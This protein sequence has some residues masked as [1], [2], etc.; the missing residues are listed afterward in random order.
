MKRLGFG[1]RITAPLPIQQ[2][3]PAPGQGIVAIETR[4]DDDELRRVLATMS[5]AAAATSFEAERTLVTALGGGCQLPLGGIAVHD[6]SDLEMH[7]IVLSPDGTRVI[8][9]SG[10]ASVA[11]PAE[12]GKRVADDLAKEGAIGILNEVR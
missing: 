5:D 10:R 11:C 4:S 12:L 7:A 3:I 1:S 9:K 6:G 2:C 8:R